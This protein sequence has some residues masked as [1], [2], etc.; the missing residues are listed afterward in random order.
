MLG[1]RLQSLN[2][3]EQDPASNRSCQRCLN[4]VAEY[5]VE[6]LKQEQGQGWQIMNNNGV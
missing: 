1:Q 5:S 3:T 2:A 6:Y 4:Y